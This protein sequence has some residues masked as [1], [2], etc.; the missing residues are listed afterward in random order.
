MQLGS[1][2]RTP[3]SHLAIWLS[4]QH[5]CSG[6]QHSVFLTSQ[7]CHGTRRV[8]CSAKEEKKSDVKVINFT[9]EQSAKQLTEKE[10]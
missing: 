8:V 1:T 6:L 10:V 2:D 7:L 9:V 3:G 4:A 5:I